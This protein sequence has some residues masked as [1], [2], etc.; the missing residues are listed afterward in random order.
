MLDEIV[1]IEQLPVLQNKVYS[2]IEKARNAV[3]GD[4]VLVQDTE[5]GLIY[6][7]AFDPR[8]LQYD[9]DY[10]NEQA[11]SCAFKRHLDDVSSL[12]E[13][14]F[15]GLNLLEV[16]CGKGHF[17][18]LLKK[19][20]YSIKGIDPAYEGE[21]PDIIK[22]HFWAGSNVKGD[23]IVLRHVLEHMHD[24]LSFLLAI[25]EANGNKGYIYI[26]V[27]CF[28]W[29]C[30]NRAWFDIYY[31]HVNYFRLSDFHRIFGNVLEGGFVFNKQYLYVIADLASL[32]APLMAEAEKVC[33]PSGFFGGIQSIVNA[34]KDN[35][36][37]VIWGSSSKG[38]IFSLY[39]ARHGVNVS[40]A[41]DI[42]PAKQGKYLAGSGLV[43][44]SP[45]D[46]FTS[47]SNGDRIFVMNENYLEEI[48]ECSGNR[49]IY[50]Q[51]R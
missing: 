46:A 21:N 5:S 27:P 34:A 48:V 6:N 32:R 45:E 22:E 36:K 17:L 11:H 13:R 47:M 26:E 50:H 28:D 20:G 19:R 39:M 8:L 3:T 25:A 37:N 41:I 44:R 23:A 7:S 49:Y 15:N 12:I 30:A 51:V 29:I 33:L 4:V 18:E 24:P 16:G 40:F 10:Q 35:K 1:R 31:E 9:Q 42:N 14:H 38:V 2:T 43:V